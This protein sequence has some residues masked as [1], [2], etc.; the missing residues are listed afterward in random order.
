M[1]SAKKTAGCLL[2]AQQ[3]RHRPGRNSSAE[4]RILKQFSPLDGLTVKRLNSTMRRFSAI[5][6][7]LTMTLSCATRDPG[8]PLRPGYNTFS[9][10][11][12]IE[13]GKEYSAEVKKQADIVDNPRL[14]AFV[15]R[16]GMHLAQQPQADDYPYEFTLINQPSIN[17]F[18]LPGGPIFVHSGL[19]DAADNEAQLAGVLS[20]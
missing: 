7:A 17:A 9:K 3:H 13:I 2:V 1:E 19:I 5:L 14:Q 11:Q 8:D 15:K 18:A 4:A 12:D 20:H 6:I 16:I 10:E